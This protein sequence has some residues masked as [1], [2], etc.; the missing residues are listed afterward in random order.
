MSI[1]SA[2]RAAGKILMVLIWINLVDLTQHNK[3]IS[4]S[5]TTSKDIALLVMIYALK[6]VGTIILI[7]IITITTSISISN[8][9]NITIITTWEWAAV[10]ALAIT[11]IV[12]TNQGAA[13]PSVG[14][15]ITNSRTIA[16]EHRTAT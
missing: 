12:L 14:V 8:S 3:T 15:T 1:I 13:C 16:F 6:A 7:T 11:R 10:T 4:S 5:T 9:T 2:E